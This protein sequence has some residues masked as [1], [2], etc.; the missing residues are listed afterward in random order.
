MRSPVRVLYV[1]DSLLPGGAER[2]LA[3]MAPALGRRGVELHVVPL[4]DRPGVQA[5]LEAAGAVLHPA[6]G[7]V[8]WAAL[9]PLRRLI[10]DVAPDLVHTTLFEADVAGRL[11]ARAAGRPSVTSLVNTSYLPSARAHAVAR[12]KRL[13][14][15]AADAATARL[16]V[17]FH[18]VSRS[19]AATMGRV[20]RIDPAKVEVVPRGRDLAALGRRTAQRRARV[21]SGLGLAATT[22]VV[23]AVAR[24]DPRK[25]LDVLVA[26]WP[27]VAAAVPGAVLLVAGRDGPASAS[28]RAAVA[29]LPDPAAVRLL[30]H[31][32]DVAD[33]MAAADVMALCSRDEG[34]PGALLEAL[35]L[36]VP[37]VATNIGPVREVVD[38]GA[39]ARLVPYGDAPA[40]AAALSETLRQPPDGQVLTQGRA[41]MERSFSI[42]A[43]S[44]AMAGF[45]DRSLETASQHRQGGGGRSG[46]RWY[47]RRLLP[48]R[49]P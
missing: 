49:S 29:T 20:L 2:S 42:E 39:P 8:R 33:V 36:E 41:V 27:T 13:A 26:A 25:G 44:A 14:A 4:I 12:A 15:M 32:Q 11:A 5:E 37:V 22:P 9:G 46:G 30:G 7:A 47:G 16:A 17:R 45:Y 24:H 34:L 19:V 10:R 38:A 3:A 21:R 48:P 43:V 35:G 31:R 40:L 18:A 1:I 6:V 23:L 28:L